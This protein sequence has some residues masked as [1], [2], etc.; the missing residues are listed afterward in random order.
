MTLV[1]TTSFFDACTIG[2]LNPHG[3]EGMTLEEA[4]A[5]LIAADV[6]YPA[7]DEDGQ[8]AARTLNVN[9][10]FGWALAWGENVPDDKM[11]EVARLFRS[12]GLAGLLYWVSEQ[13]GQMRSEF[14]DNNRSI[15]FVRHEENLRKKMPDSSKRAYH[16]LVYILGEAHDTRRDCK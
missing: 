5:L 15:D 10:V 14:H 13:H 1:Q 7:D 2:P 3:E 11:V 9:D 6:F 8:E 16:K 4:R 12:Y